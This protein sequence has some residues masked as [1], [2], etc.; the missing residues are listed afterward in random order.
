VAAE[1]QSSDA[2]LI[3]AAVRCRIEVKVPA[4]IM[5]Q[6]PMHGNRRWQP[7]AST[8][9]DATEESL[10]RNK[11]LALLKR[12]AQ[13]VLFSGHTMQALKVHWPSAPSASNH[14][15]ALQCVGRGS[16]SNTRWSGFNEDTA[17]EGWTRAMVLRE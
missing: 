11:R 2:A 12:R 10:I 9:T 6:L 15:C 7:P 13:R 1:R 17:G 4:E 14:A 5:Q 3:A 8:A 16:V